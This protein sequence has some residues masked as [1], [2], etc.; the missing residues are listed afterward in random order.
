MAILLVILNGDDDKNGNSSIA[1]T[2]V[3]IMTMII[4][5]P[6]ITLVR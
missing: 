5:L 6:L 1:T 4:T 3:A 2:R